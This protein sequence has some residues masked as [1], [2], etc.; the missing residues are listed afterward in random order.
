MRELD[1]KTGTI[2]TYESKDRIDENGKDV[3]ILPVREWLAGK[4]CEKEISEPKEFASNTQ[5]DEL[6]E[7]ILSVI[8]RN[9]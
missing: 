9:P 2:L 6:S 7:P 5:K 4:T 3:E 1:V 8:S